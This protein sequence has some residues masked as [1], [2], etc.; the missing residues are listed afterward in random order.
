MKALGNI[1][2]FAL[3]V[4]TL[5]SAASAAEY[6]TP[7]GYVNDFAEVLTQEQGAALNAELVA[8]EQKTTI[9]IAVVTV[10]WLE[11]Q[12]VEA[13]ADGLGTE[14]GVGKRGANNGIVFLIALQE[15]EMRIHTAPGARSLLP[16]YK[17][18]RIRDNTVIPSFKKAVAA[19]KRGDEAQ[20]RSNMAQGIIDGTREIMRVI[21]ASSAA[22]VV[23]RRAETPASEPRP[24]WS[25]EQR[26]SVLL[27]AFGIMAGIALLLALIIPPV[28]RSNAR[29]YVLANKG[30]VAERFAE[31]AR[32]VAHADVTEKTRKAFKD[33]RGK[34][35]RIEALHEM[36]EGINWIETREE[37]DAM[38]WP[39]RRIVSSMDDDVAYAEKARKEGPELMR[40]LPGMIEEA[41]AKILAGKSPRAAQH[42][43]EAR[44]RYEEAQRQSSG[45]SVLDWVILYAILSSAH[46]NVSDAEASHARASGTGSWSSRN[47]RSRSSD[48]DDR[49]SS[50]GFG[51]GGGGG[52]GGGSFGGGSGGS[53]GGW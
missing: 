51:F 35:S 15:R 47:S 31:A 23:E 43:A 40:K 1:L 26:N 5:A 25:P 14:W 50:S 53:S 33:L 6:P 10:P 38:D 7:T 36:S 21:D 18:D 52:F 17:A 29:R 3:L 9:E 8:F 27:T 37:L 34:F 11:G 46:S 19:R 44:A 49:S 30:S 4:L 48:D 42:L 32:K 41:E 13:Y 24:G 22:P 28:R 39:L 20:W 12:S 45:M 16:D 2:L